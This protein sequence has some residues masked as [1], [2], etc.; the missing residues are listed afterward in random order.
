MHFLWKREK[1]IKKKPSARNQPWYIDMCLFIRNRTQQH[2]QWH[3]EKVGLATGWVCM[4]C[5]NIVDDT[6]FIHIYALTT[7]A[8]TW[9]GNI[10]ANK[11]IVSQHRNTRMP[12]MNLRVKKSHSESTQIPLDTCL[13]FCLF[14][15]II[16]IV[17]L[18]YFKLQ[19][20]K[21]AL[22]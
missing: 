14:K 9:C 2:I 5:P 20:I 10:F 1:I 8:W 19:K 16:I 3:D 15:G 12:F 4:C 11:I 13:D 7:D 22:K 6:F 17:F 18:L 21:K